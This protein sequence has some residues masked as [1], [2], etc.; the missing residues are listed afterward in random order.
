MLLENYKENGFCIIR[1]ALSKNKIKKIRSEIFLP[2]SKRLGNNKIYDCNLFE[3]FNNNF[4]AYC[5]CAKITH[6][7]PSVHKLG[8]S[9]KVLGFIKNELNLEF[10]VI[11]TRPVILFSSKHLAKHHFY[12]KSNAHQDSAIMQGSTDAVIVWIPLCK[13]SEKLGYLQV[14]PKSHK[15]GVLEHKKNGP[16]K[17]IDKEIPDEEFVEIKMNMGDILF[18][19][20]NLIHRSGNNISKKIRLT[21]SYRF[22]NLLNENYIKES[23]PIGFEYVMK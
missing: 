10:P 11:N 23:Y 19:S 3:L 5:S 20:S 8:L 7:I 18:F 12:W 15:L 17:E 2:F 14:V 22:D 16:S 6:Q 4:E 21:V 1:N 9:N 13:I